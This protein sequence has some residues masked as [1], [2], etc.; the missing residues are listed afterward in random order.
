MSLAHGKL[1]RLET[2]FDLQN[3]LHDE[4]LKGRPAWWHAGKIAFGALILAKAFGLAMTASSLGG[5]AMALVLFVCGL[6][7]A[8][9]G[10]RLLLERWLMRQS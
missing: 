9:E 10:A 2:W 5:Y 7:L 8:L 6:A 4:K 1:D 3:A